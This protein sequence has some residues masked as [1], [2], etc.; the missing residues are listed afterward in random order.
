ML[1]LKTMKNNFESMISELWMQLVNCTE[2]CGGINKNQKEGI[3]PRC[4]FFEKENRN[5]KSKG[6]IIVGLNPGISGTEEREEYKQK[7]KDKTINEHWKT[8]PKYKYYTNLRKFVNNAGLNGIILWTEL[9]KCECNPKKKAKDIP[10]QTYRNCVNRYLLKEIK[11]LDNK[12]IIVAVGR[13]T[14]KALSYLFPKRAIIGVPHPTSSKGQFSKLFCENK[15]KKDVKDNIDNVI[16]TKD[17]IWL[18]S[19]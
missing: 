13:E 8:K 7:I 9:V 11:A 10:L 2:S 19:E 18:K 14:H 3:I 17:T 16:Y 6:C 5:I 4:L 12:W 15:L 1:K